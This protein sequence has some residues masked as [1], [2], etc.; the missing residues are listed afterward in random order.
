MHINSNNS[1]GNEAGRDQNA[2]S[3]TASERE[4]RLLSDWSY[5]SER[6]DSRKAFNETYKYQIILPL[7]MQFT[8]LLLF[9]ELWEDKSQRR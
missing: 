7:K 2:G 5:L 4:W 6:K 9:H 3:D 8:E 1:N